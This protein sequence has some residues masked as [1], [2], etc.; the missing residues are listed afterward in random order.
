LAALFSQGRAGCVRPVLQAASTEVEAM[1]SPDQKSLG[2]AAGAEPAGREELTTA[3]NLYRRFR[4][5]EHQAVWGGSYEK[6]QGARRAVQELGKA[7]W[8]EMLRVLDA[9][10]RRGHPPATAGDE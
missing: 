7:L 9:A 5:A 1:T 10:V 6:E 3:L 2:A 4:D 8:D